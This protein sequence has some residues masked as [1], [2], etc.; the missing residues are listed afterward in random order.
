MAPGEPVCPDCGSTFPPAAASC[1]QCGAARPATPEKAAPKAAAVSADHQASEKRSGELTRRVSRLKQWDEAGAAL[2]V[3]L[4][5]LPNWAEEVTR[6]G[7][8]GD[9]WLEVVRGI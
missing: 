3:R 7:H 2:G 4:P 9:A 6:H 5:E 1:P 8:G